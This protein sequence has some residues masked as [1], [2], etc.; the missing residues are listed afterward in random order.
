M[1]SISVNDISIR[2]A[3]PED[4]NFIF[5]AILESQ[6]SDSKLGKS[7]RTSIFNREFNKVIDY[8]LSTSKVA[9]ACVKEEANVI[10]GFIIS[11][12]QDV[13]HYI[14]VKD[15]FKKLRVASILTAYALGPG[16]EDRLLQCS[17]MTGEAAKIIKRQGMKIDH[18]PFILFHK[19]IAS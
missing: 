16:Y 4:L 15:G 5:N 7:C 18:N 8:L 17:L 2:Q 9:I 11:N 3:K 1:P 12:G 13:I 19:G 6:K 10:I 14:F